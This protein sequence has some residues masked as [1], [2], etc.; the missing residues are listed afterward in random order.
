MSHTS[1]RFEQFPVQGR[2][3]AQP[4]SADDQR[5]AQPNSCQCEFLPAG[6]SGLRVQTQRHCLVN[7]QAHSRMF[8]SSRDSTEVRRTHRIAARDWQCVGAT[9]NDDQQRR[10][11]QNP[12]F[13]CSSHARTRSRVRV[14][15][16][17]CGG[18]SA[19]FSAVH[20]MHM[21]HPTAAVSQLQSQNAGAWQS[22]MTSSHVGHSVSADRCRSCKQ[23]DRRIVTLA[24]Q[25]PYAP[26]RRAIRGRLNAKRW[27]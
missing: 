4:P 9:L 11:H 24:R 26:T 23:I 25:R 12:T 22:K 21:P 19:L 10:R 3:R 5:H 7:C 17:S 18:S 8:S 6:S 27:R 16:S 14:C 2:T 20:N 13:G 1:R 15:A